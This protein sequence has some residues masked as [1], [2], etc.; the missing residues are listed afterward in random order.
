MAIYD[1]PKD[2]HISPPHLL[3]PTTSLVTSLKEEGTWTN[4]I[5]PTKR[6]KQK[7]SSHVLQ[8]SVGNVLMMQFTE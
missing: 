4:D 6:Y 8:K 5:L 3:L 7:T 2:N 1:P